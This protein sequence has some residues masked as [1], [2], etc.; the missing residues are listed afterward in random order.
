MTA[1]SKSFEIPKQA[2]WDA[3]LQVKR[4]KGGPGYDNESMNIFEN[5]LKNN[6]Y[7]IWNRMSSGTY[8]PPPV[9]EVEIPK[10]DGKVRKLGIPTISDRIAQTVVK[11]IL[12]P[13]VDP[14]FH[15]DSYG[16]RPNKSALQA[17]GQA[18]WRCWRDDW[19]LD[20][21]IKSFFDSIDHKLMIAAVKKFTQAPW[22]L[23]YIERWLKADVIAKDGIQK[24]RNLGTPQ[25]G[26]ISP[27]LAN[28][29]LHFTFDKWMKENYPHIHFER[30]ADD[31]VIHCRSLMQLE[32]I[33]GKLKKRLADCKLAL[34]QQKTK[35]VYCKDANRNENWKDIAFDFLGY[36]FRPRL[37]RD[38]KKEFF[39]SFSPA[40]SAKAAKNIRHTV[41]NKW[42]L[43]M[44]MELDIEELA[45]CYNPVIQ[46]W[47]NYYSRFH[48]S[49]L[50]SK[51]FE[52][53][54][55]T[56]MRWAMK[57]YKQLLRRPTRASRWLKRAQLEN[58]NLFAH[59]KFKAA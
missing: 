20:I 22:V 38:K 33:E 35:R 13:V 21:D 51:V 25:G 48:G 17:I 24:K 3:Y 55:T 52:Y 31:I 44:K 40:I 49:A 11:Q 43:K 27:L 6:L 4:S 36:T 56:L 42:K 2:V 10:G 37:A 47:I 8:F 50:Y 53:L 19:V 45:V 34:N 28:I 23:L 54:N 5:D 46:G 7:K 58:P 57:K 32:M 39:V 41:K 16:Y 15:E 26:V 30:Y 12:E 59:W 9:L 14:H 1:K 29:Y 18:R